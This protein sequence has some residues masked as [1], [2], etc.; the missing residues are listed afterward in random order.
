M[1]LRKL[2]TPWIRAIRGRPKPLMILPVECRAESM[3]LGILGYLGHDNAPACRLCD[4]INSVYWRVR[5]MKKKTLFG[6]NELI[7]IDW[8]TLE[9][10]RKDLFKEAKNKHGRNKK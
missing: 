4:C 5:L 8:P 7:R 6:D 9:D 3:R 10:I 1:I 2:D